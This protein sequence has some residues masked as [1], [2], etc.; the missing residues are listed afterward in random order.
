MAEPRISR[1]DRIVSVIPLPLLRAAAMGRLVTPFYHVVSAKPLAHIRHLY[2]YKSPAAFE[3]DLIHFKQNFHPVSH[4]QIVEHINGGPRLKPGSA[5]IT[6]DD[7]LT[8][9]FTIVRPLLLR[10]GIPCT[11]FVCKN[12]MDNRSLMHR[13]KVSLCVEQLDVLSDQ[14]VGRAA[15]L[16][17]ERNGPSLTSRAQT[18]AWVLGLD[19]RCLRQVD[20]ACD[21]LGI[22]I[23]RFLQ[24]KRPY[25]SSAEVKQLHDDGFTIGGHTC[26][27]VELDKLSDWSQVTREIVESCEAVC[28]LTHQDMVPFAIPFNGVN[29]PRNALAKLREDCA[30]IDVIYDT[31]NL[32]KDRRFIINRIWCDTPAGDAEQCSN[33]GILVRRAYALGATDIHY[34]RL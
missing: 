22:D 34:P 24:E 28:E 3:R 12:F 8:E 33:L 31:N 25:M 6:F 4:E 20:E 10:H 18:R 19:S 17:S 26:S 9:C 5:H 21:A 30:C 11:F 23:N 13:N 29:L 1:L 32:M 14:E 27:H 15:K 7:G 2:S 16:L